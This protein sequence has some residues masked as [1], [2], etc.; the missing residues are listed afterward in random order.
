MDDLLALVQRLGGEEVEQ[1]DL[2]GPVGV[3]DVVDGVQDAAELLNDLLRKRREDQVEAQ[4]GVSYAAAVKG[5]LR[6]REPGVSILCPEGW[7]FHLGGRVVLSP[8]GWQGRNP[9]VLLL[10]LGAP[11]AILGIA[12]GEVVLLHHRNNC[13]AACSCNVTS[14]KVASRLS[15][16][17]LICGFLHVKL[18]AD[19]HIRINKA[20]TVRGFLVPVTVQYYKTSELT[21]TP[22]FL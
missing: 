10:L 5:G 1:P 7:Q 12:P 19:F 6:Q 22:Y 18:I 15:L 16:F 2:Q 4:L 21:G 14:V 8:R 17:I 3:G 9:D 20:Y 13:Y 11:V